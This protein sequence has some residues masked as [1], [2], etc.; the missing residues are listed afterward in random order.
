LKSLT[1]ISRVLAALTTVLLLCGAC[2]GAVPQ[3]PALSASLSAPTRVLEM[4]RSFDLTLT[5]NNTGEQEVPVREV[6]LPAGILRA[7]RY[8]GSLPAVTLEPA[9][10]GS[11]VLRTQ[12]V[13]PS[14]SSAQFV[15]RFETVFSGIYEEDFSVLFGDELI[16]LPARLEVKGSIPKDWQPGPAVAGAQSEAA[17]GLPQSALVRVGALVNVDGSLVKA[18]SA[19]GVIISPDGLIL[20]S[21]RAV[22]GS[23]F[24]PVADLIIGLQTA[25]NTSPVDAYLASIVQVN[26]A[27][28]AALIKPRSD[29]LGNPIP[30]GTLSLPAVPLAK[31]TGMLPGEALS[32]LGYSSSPEAL[33]STLNAAVTGLVPE[34]ASAPLT[35]VLTNL[36]PAGDYFAWAA[37][38]ARGELIG[39]ASAPTGPVGLE[40]GAL[41]DTN[42]DGVLDEQDA[43]LPA[44]G[45]LQAL[46]SVQ[47]LEEMLAAGWAGEVGLRRVSVSGVPFDMQGQVVF[48]TDFS[49]PL[50]AWQASEQ[51][52]ARSAYEDGEFVLEV[53]G[54]R[55]LRFATLDYVYDDLTLSADTRLLAG[56]GDGDYGF[57][58]GFQDASHF[59]ALEVSEDGYF[60]IWKRAGDETSVLVD[61]T[62]ADVLISGE[63]LRLSAQCGTGALRLAA[64]GL[65]L[66]EYVDKEFSPGLVGILAGTYAGGQIIVAFDNLEILIP[67]AE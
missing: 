64:N 60:S 36:P 49:S 27:R 56:S 41:A 52:G 21:A 30:P 29:L 44:G 57:V 31:D 59:T 13:I 48:E 33:T 4:G 47:A 26:E 43:C 54:T 12:L 62:Y 45:N 35:S 55:Q 42:R 7:F 51:E 25:P 18:W 34:D 24:Y 39:L 28:D 53:S 17:D 66:T 1:R 46:T 20:T 2:L 50:P 9:A 58:C 37:F 23:R 3:T 32:L 40:C 5:L 10:D 65:L 11:G 6:R 38:N 19:S 14:Q 67:G 61:W 63:G 22:L 16:S 8:Q 15:L